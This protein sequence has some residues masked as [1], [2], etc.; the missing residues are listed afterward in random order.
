M[1]MKFRACAL[2]LLA[3]LAVVLPAQAVYVNP[4]GT[5]QVLLFPYYTANGGQRTLVRIVNTTE[6]AKLLYVAFKEGY[7]ARPVRQVMLALGPH[8][9]WNVS[10]GSLDGETPAT[11]HSVDPSCTVPDKPQWTAVPGGGWSI[12]ALS[13][14]YTDDSTDSGPTTP[15][16]TREGF[17]EVIEAAQLQGALAAAASSGPARRCGVFGLLDDASADLQPPGGGLSGQFAVVDV[18]QGTYIG[19]RATALADFTPVHL[20][21]AF[22]DWLS[23]EQAHNAPGLSYAD[24]L[25]DGAPARLSYSSS[26]PPRGI[27]AV[28]A[29]LAADTL[30]ADVAADAAAGSFTDWVLTLP[31]KFAYTDNARLGVPVGGGGAVAPFDQVFGEV[32]AGA[33]CSRY[34]ATGYSDEGAAISFNPVASALPAKSLCRAV[35]VLSFA[36]LGPSAATPVLR[37]RLGAS[38]W[39][40][41]PAFDGGRVQLDFSHDNAGQPRRLRPGLDGD[42]A[43]RGLPLLGFAAYKYTNGN[44]K[45]GAL[46][47][48]LLQPLSDSTAACANAQGVV[49]CP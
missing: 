26:M 46:A 37:S 44:S 2:L 49:A 6:R 24:F 40:P 47:E 32:H 36:P 4:R 43:V 1:L 39:N 13:W 38:L 19:G 25:R 35:N 10:L 15:A 30:S 33:S 22:G 11:L 5:G 20:V 17:V 14:A 31:T 7:N 16:R 34:E 28:S 23:L 8:D 3:G 29:V 9:A 27:D 21:N 42:V 48:M 12:N 45:P 18:A 41:Q